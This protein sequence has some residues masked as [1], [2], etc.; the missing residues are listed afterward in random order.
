[1][2]IA[3]LTA[4]LILSALLVACGDDNGTA[5]EV[6]EP[7]MIRGLTPHDY[8]QQNCASCHGEQRQGVVGPPLG[9]ADLT[10]DDAHY[11]RIIRDGVQRSPMPAWGRQLNETHIALLIEYLRT[12]P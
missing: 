7:G 2:R 12:E 4:L 9:P 6:D 11:A 8:F 5:P 3:A 10:Q 1:M